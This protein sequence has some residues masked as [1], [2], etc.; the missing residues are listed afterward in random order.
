Y[1]GSRSDGPFQSRLRYK[2]DNFT[3]NFTWRKG[4]TQA[5]GIRLNLGRND[6]FSSGQIPLDEVAAGR[7]DRFGAVDPDGGGR[8]RNGTLGL[9]YRKESPEGSVF[10]LDGFLAR[11]LFG[12]YSNFTFYLND[13]T[14]GD[15]IQQ[16]DSR[17]QE[18]ANV[19]V[20]HPHRVFGK[21]MLLNAGGNFHQ[22]QIQVGLYP[23]VGR[24]PIGIATK[25]HAQVT[26]FA[27][28]LQQGMDAWKGR[29]HLEAGLRLDYFRFGVR[30]E[31]NPADA[32]TQGA[33]RLQPKLSLSLTPSQ[34]VP[35]TLYFNYGRGISSQ[36]ARGVVQKPSGI[37]ISTTDFYQAGVSHH[38]KRF[39]ASA[40]VFW[41]DRSS[42][43]VYVPDDGSI[44]F[45]GPSRAY[46][47]ELKA[48]W[49]LPRRLTLHGGITQVSNAFYRNTSPRVYVDSS[50]HTVANAALTLSPWRGLSGSLRYRHAGNYRLDGLERTLRASGLDV[51]DLSVEKTLRQGVALSLAVDNLTNKVYYETQN[52]FASRLK[53][54]DPVLGRIHGTPGYPITVTVGL[55]LRLSGK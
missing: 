53:P 3:G 44:E 48:S 46:G 26:N 32:G 4:E 43:Q 8:V 28:Y 30:D 49:E 2:R 39:S 24:T 42:E 54:D 31:A 37:R 55:T 21:Q 52:Y 1:E 47:A 45:R 14:D 18:G 51:L 36:D 25:A 12:L 9:Y 33:S 38:L 15:E 11:S 34:R 27:G 35:A 20:L 10:K 41:I 13:R 23:S 5:A 6:F 22:N 19:Q 17:L 7:L 16:H 50:P 40:D 29:V